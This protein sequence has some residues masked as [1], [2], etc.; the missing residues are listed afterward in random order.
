MFNMEDWL[1]EK[2]QA[3]IWE[4][5]LDC[6]QILYQKI[7]ERK[8]ST[9][10]QALLQDLYQIWDARFIMFSYSNSTVTWCSTRLKPIFFFY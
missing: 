6:A 2:I 9:L 10:E 8:P 1:C 5:I 3:L 4:G 7:L